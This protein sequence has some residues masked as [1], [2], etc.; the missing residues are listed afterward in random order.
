MKSKIVFLSLLLVFSFMGCPE[1][2]KEKTFSQGITEINSLWEKNNVNPNFLVN[3]SVEDFSSSDLETLNDDLLSFQ[4]SLD[5]FEG[6]EVEALNDFTEI[7][8]LLT[9]ALNSALEL[10]TANNELKGKEITGDNLCSNKT[11]LN[12]VGEK[13]VLLNEK[14][15]E[16]N[17]LVYAFNEV[18]P[19]FQEQANLSSFLAEDLGFSRSELENQIAL[20]ELERLCP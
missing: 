2:K 10:K 7:H 11:L 8:L 3:D 13:T 19:G 17:E 16:I 6:N 14:M 1:Q 12:S 18:H 5:G 20:S 4:S 15:Q 9:A